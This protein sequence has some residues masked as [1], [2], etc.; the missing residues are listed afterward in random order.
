MMGL[1]CNF[2]ASRDPEPPHSDICGTNRH[3]GEKNNRVNKGVEG[4]FTEDK[5]CCV[6]KIEMM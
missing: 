6:D 5:D 1:K 4:V 3:W 2:F